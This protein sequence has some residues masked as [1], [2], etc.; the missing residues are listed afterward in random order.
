MAGLHQTAA[1]TTNPPMPEL[2]EAE[3]TRL[4]LEQTLLHQTIANATVEEDRIVFDGR[5]KRWVKSKLQARRVEG[6]HR[7]GKYLWLELDSAPHPIIHLGMTGTVRVRG[8]VPLRLSSSPKEVDESWPPRFTKL[9]L[10]TKD[11]D[12]VAYTNA[13]RLGRILFRNEPVDEKPMSKLGFDPLT[14]MATQAEFAIRIR[15]R[16]KAILKALLLDQTFAAGVGNWIADEVLYQASLDPRRRVNSL[17]DREVEQLRKKIRHVVQ[18][19]V[20]ANARK[21]RFPKTWLFHHRW[22]KQ[23]D[24]TTSRGEPIEYVEISGRT[25]AWVPSRQR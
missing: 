15:R 7:K 20:K 8:V 5:A 22:G 18:T 11:G 13:R 16:P 6:V 25:T 2:P 4:I 24:Q 23:P 9:L 12:E 3:H 10:A 14:E 17:S 21:D 1:R 19:A